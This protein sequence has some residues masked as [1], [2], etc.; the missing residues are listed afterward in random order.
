MEIQQEKK[1]AFRGRA[2]VAISNLRFEDAYVHGTRP[3]DSSNIDR[4]EKIFELEGC[5]RLDPD[6]YVPAIINRDTFEKALRNSGLQHD[7]LN[8]SPDE[9]K[10]LNLDPQSYLTCLHGRHRLA[11]ARRFLDP[12]ERWWVVDIYSDG[13]LLPPDSEVC[14]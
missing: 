1:A 9:P 2:K 14:C 8:T 11:A 3:L 10:W 7:L 12:S 6:H 13:L 5:L 4:L